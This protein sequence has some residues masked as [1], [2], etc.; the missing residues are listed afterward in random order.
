M[1]KS[2]YARHYTARV[3]V[4]MVQENAKDR[5]QFHPQEK[6]VLRNEAWPV[7][8]DILQMRYED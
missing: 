2:T 5:E 1:K 6:P 8:N 7:R 3:T 4:G